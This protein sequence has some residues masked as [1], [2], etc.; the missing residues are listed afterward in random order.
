MTRSKA[1]KILRE[2]VNTICSL[3]NY[4]PQVVEDILKADRLVL[5]E[6]IADNVIDA[7]NFPD[8]VE[9]QLP[10]MGSFIVERLTKGRRGD[11]SYRFIPTKTFHKEV[12]NA[13]YYG[14]TPLLDIMEKNLN[15]LVKHRS[16]NIVREVD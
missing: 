6:Q 8:E 9:L 15:D 4:S 2:H 14:K 3:T 10:K 12:L 1:S 7:D 16:D 11:I 13:F 5:L